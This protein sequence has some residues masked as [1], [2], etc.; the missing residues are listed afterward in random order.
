MISLYSNKTLTKTEVGTRK[1]GI[2][3][4]GLNMLLFGG[5][6]TLKLWI[7]KAVE[8]NWEVDGGEL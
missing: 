5:V 7:K 4:M 2:A 6:W 8:R 1:W 3:V